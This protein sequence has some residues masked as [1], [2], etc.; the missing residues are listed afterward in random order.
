MQAEPGAMDAD[1]HRWYALGLLM[2][3]GL[4]NYID[5]NCMAILQLPIARELE[6]TDTE[7]GVLTGLSFWLVY[8]T[9]TVPLAVLAD[10][11]SRRLVIAGA[12]TL[13]SL[14]TFACGFA[15]SF[16]ALAVLRM[17][18]AVGEAGCAP[19]T[20]ALLSDYFPLHQRGRAIA[21]WT[22]VYPLGT[23]IGVGSG[24]WLS[25]SFGWRNTFLLL[26][27]IG[28]LLGPIVLL[29]LREPRRSAGA[30]SAADEAKPALRASLAL[31]WRSPSVRNSALGGLFLAYPLNVEVAWNAPFYSRIHGLSLAELALWLALLTGGVGAIGMWTGG[32]LADRLGRTDARWY[33]RLPAVAGFGVVPFMLAQYF[34][35]D[36]R[37]SLACGVPATLLLNGYIAAQAA[38]NQ[39]MVAPRLRA[40]CSGLNIVLAGTCGAALAPFATGVLSDLLTRHSGLGRNG[41]RYAMAAGCVFGV[42]A[43]MYFLRAAQHFPAEL[44]R[45]AAERP[46]NTAAA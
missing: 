5:R 37:L 26:G 7:L 8:T 25:Q 17:G 35:A 3:V 46:A 19:S 33:L 14:M 24:G 43:G 20:H 9:M 27:A 39:S 23:L 18:V 31:L 4:C 16:L 45:R 13:W 42:V 11:S 38:A 28:L 6:L 15:T 29:T 22:L 2:L 12:V 36:F 1:R 40:L 30:S 41:L 21:S 44:A 34:V 10:R 32:F